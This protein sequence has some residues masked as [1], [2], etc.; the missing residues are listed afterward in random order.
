MPCMLKVDSPAQHLLDC[1]YMKEIKIPYILRLASILISLVLLVMML[2]YLKVVMVPLFFS[3][4]F[5]IMLFPVCMRLEK[6]GIGRGF[7]SFITVFLGTLILGFLLYT[8]FVQ[9]S[10]FA[11]QIPQIT[12][13]L[14]A[15][16]D[17]L[18]DLMV[19]KF[20]MTKS[21]A[22][23]KIK[24]QLAIL[25]NN[26]GAMLTHSLST[27][28]A[29][30]INA[31]LIPLYVFFLLFYR[32][33][34]IEFFYKVFTS[35]DRTLIDETILKISGV[36]KGYLFGQFLDV[37]IIG[38]VNSFA[39]YLI[40]VGYPIIL[41]F[42]ISVFCIIPYI[43]MII[44]SILA[45]VTAFITTT[46][47]WQPLTALMVLWIIHIID[48]NLISPMVIGSRV[49]INPL[50]GIFML[51]L[52]GELWGLPGLFL[53]FPLTA[54]LKV[55]FD[56]VPALKPYGF[57]LGE[58]EKYHLKRYSLVHIKRL[59]SIV[60]KRKARIDTEGITPTTQ[61]NKSGTNSAA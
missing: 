55:I 20:S 26:G 27:V 33:F 46:S 25:Q 6:W 45:L 58:P 50:M 44:G 2:F 29:L 51:F 10:N 14:S 38:I 21:A 23:N 9:L 39:L 41:G 17:E 19:K 37:L 12:A 42:C 24:E 5:A 11:T 15:F 32:H 60:Q 1:L 48:S 28:S 49:D 7:S 59:H 35:S 13:R 47:E 54:I 40:G 36:V 18:R 30:L 52:F 22:G 61:A 57:L 34:F 8:L 31:F 56:T 4:I 53:A 43:G 16:I 3:I